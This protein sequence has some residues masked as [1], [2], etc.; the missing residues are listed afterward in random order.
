MR[1][2][3]V[4]FN[5]SRKFFNDLELIK[6]AII[7]GK[8]MKDNDYFPT[9]T[10]TLAELDLATGK[11]TV[12]LANSDDGSKEDTI[13]KNKDRLILE[14]I[15]Q[16]LA[17]YVQTIS[18]GDEEIIASAGFDLHKEASPIG[19]LEQAE[20]LH[21]EQDSNSGVVHVSCNV[22]EHA[23]NYEFQYAEA[24]LQPQSV[25]MHNVT[26]K[27]QVTLNGLNPGQIYLFRVAGFGTD[28]TRTWSEILTRMII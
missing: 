27:H 5:F 16:K 23:S 7:I 3:K 25:W 4:L 20:G 13:I 6:K 17:L 14:N 1:F 22:V 15:L 21:V 28:P 11:F 10:P 19:P 24:P 2:I 26:S 18:E 12:S 8:L 9:P